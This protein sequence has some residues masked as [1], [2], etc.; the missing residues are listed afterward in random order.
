MREEAEQ[1]ARAEEL[2]ARDQAARQEAAKEE[3]A[4]AR[5]RQEAAA[6]EEAARARREASEEAQAKRE[7]QR[8]AKAA[9]AEARAAAAAT[10]AAASA[11]SYRGLA[12]GGSGLAQTFR[13]LSPV[14]LQ[15][16]PAWQGEARAPG[17]LPTPVGGG[18]CRSHSRSASGDAWP[19]WEAAD[20]SQLWADEG[21]RKGLPHVWEG[22]PHVPS[23][24]LDFATADARAVGGAS[25]PAVGSAALG[26]A[27]LVPLGGRDIAADA[28]GGP[29]GLAGVHQ[30]SGVGCGL[31]Y[32][33]GQL[34]AATQGFAD[35]SACNR[36]GTVHRGVLAASAT[37]VAVKRVPPSGRGPRSETAR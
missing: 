20:I 16:E 4:A 27:T 26:G 31:R 34:A 24:A 5:A 17:G 32:T 9:E 21:P 35:A 22:R 3:A 29:G 18:T 11:A 8:L 28:P 1:I 2:A 15:N 12:A 13:S 30:Q 6:K 23:G 25:A 14:D 19:L 36:R 10:A 37:P 7:A 33:H